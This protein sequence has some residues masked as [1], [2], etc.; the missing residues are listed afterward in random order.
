M[1]PNGRKT[2]M[3][4]DD[5]SSLRKDFFSKAFVKKALGPTAQSIISETNATIYHQKTATVILKENRRKTLIA[6]QNLE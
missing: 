5:G 1:G 3:A 6:G 2:K 4:L